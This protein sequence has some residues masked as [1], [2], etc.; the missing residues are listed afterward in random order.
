ML[1]TLAI[2]LGLA[3]LCLASVLA[4]R[5][6][7]PL[8]ALGPG[9][10]GALILLGTL[11]E[12]FRYRRLGDAPPGAGLDGH[13]R[14]FS[15][16]GDRCVGRGLLSSRQR[17]AALHTLGVFSHGGFIARATLIRG[18]RHRCGIDGPS[19]SGDVNIRASGASPERR[20]FRNRSAAA[21]R[22]RLHRLHATVFRLFLRG[23]RGRIITRRIGNN[24]ISNHPRLDRPDAS[25]PGLATAQ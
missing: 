22:R 10:M 2:L 13:R 11:F 4:G 17:R 7:T 20:A 19:G 24:D 15:R 25:E 21:S 1:R 14:A 8:A 6:H 5:A 9:V 3:L 23:T 12:R 16:P 18:G